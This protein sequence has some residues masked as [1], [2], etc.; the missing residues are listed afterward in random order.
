LGSTDEKRKKN[1]LTVA[2]MK[3]AA[4]AANGIFQLRE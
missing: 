2:D 3:I 1:T 4:A